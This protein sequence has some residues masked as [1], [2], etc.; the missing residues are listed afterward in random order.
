[1]WNG[2]KGARLRISAANVKRL[3][4]EALHPVDERVAVTVRIR[5]ARFP[6]TG[7]GWC[8]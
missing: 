2:P 1:V 8:G 4:T 5:E 7:S 3:G 6:Q